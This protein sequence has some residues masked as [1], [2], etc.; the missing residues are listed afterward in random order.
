MS[1]GVNDGIAAR[2]DSAEPFGTELAAEGLVEVCSPVINRPTGETFQQN[3]GSYYEVKC[4]GR[5][6]GN[7]SGD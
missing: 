7:R 1:H 6:S 4:L 5:G 3:K 2:C